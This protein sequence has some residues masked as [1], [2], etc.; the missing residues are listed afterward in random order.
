[1]TQEICLPSLLTAMWEGRKYLCLPVE[2]AT[3][4]THKATLLV[5][6]H[7]HIHTGADTLVS[8]RQEMLPVLGLI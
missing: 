6:V 5:A 8:G 1:M 2:G 7:P 4:L 3:C